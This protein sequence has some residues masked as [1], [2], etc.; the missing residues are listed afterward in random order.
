MNYDD[1]KLASPEDYE[2]DDEADDRYCAN[3]DTEATCVTSGGTPLCATCREAYEW[4]QG[5]PDATFEDV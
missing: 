1:W 4:G 2:S 3:C 5:S